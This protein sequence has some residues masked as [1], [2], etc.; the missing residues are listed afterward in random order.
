MYADC[1]FDSGNE[2][3][4]YL[5]LDFFVQEGYNITM[6]AGQPIE[7]SSHESLNNANE[8]SPIGAEAVDVSPDT[9]FNIVPPT[10]SQ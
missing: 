3:A 7:T 6:L 8:E 5:P 9:D 1:V 4:I 10:E 2:I